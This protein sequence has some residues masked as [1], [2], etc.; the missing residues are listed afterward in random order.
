MRLSGL[1]NAYGIDP[2]GNE[3]TQQLPLGTIGFD[4]FGNKYRYVANTATALVAGNLIQANPQPANFKD[5]VVPTAVPTRTTGT[6][7]TANNKIGLT[8]GGTAVTA[9]Q[10]VGGR[11]VVSIT[12]GIGT[13]YTIASHDVQVSTTGLCNFFTEEPISVALTTSSQVT[14]TPHPYN[15]VVAAP[16][17]I[18]SFP[19]GVILTALP[20]NTT[21]PAV[22][23]YSWV[24][25]V[26][27]F[28][29]LS[30]ATLGAVGNG[31][32]P[33]VT[34]AGCITKAITLK[35]SIG[36]YI[37]VPVSAQVEPEWFNIG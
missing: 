3:T 4:P 16:T 12:P 14:V 23:Y 24:G 7:P 33:S 31:I 29:A 22:T 35:D 20:A 21:S 18:T 11:L 26:G 8:L 1:P 34:T 30:D 32:S 27:V 2:W 36:Y 5:L 6:A 19:A 15:G 37:V 13:Q 25:Q 28:G 17:T 9:G 10:F